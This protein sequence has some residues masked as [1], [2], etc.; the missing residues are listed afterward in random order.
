[1]RA[2]LATGELARERRPF[3]PGGDGADD[4]SRVVHRNERLQHREKHHEAPTA[5]IPLAVLT[6]PIAQNRPDVLACGRP[7]IAL[8]PGAVS[9]SENGR[10]LRPDALP[11][12]SLF[13]DGMRKK[14]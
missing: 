13:H 5:S 2:D 14:I 6:A 12:L 1:M 9:T 4:G 3:D 8:T 10:G 7:K 11:R